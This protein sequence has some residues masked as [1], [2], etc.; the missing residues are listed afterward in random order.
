MGK[1]FVA[2]PVN[3]PIHEVGY[4]GQ[5]QAYGCYHLSFIHCG[6]LWPV[7]RRLAGNAGSKAFE[8]S[9]VIVFCY[10]GMMEK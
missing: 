1:L 8:H 10:I 4:A 2:S 9:E 5:K 7:N 3:Y 6:V